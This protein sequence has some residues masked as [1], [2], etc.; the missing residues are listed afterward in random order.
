MRKSP[1]FVLFLFL[2]SAS[3]RAQ[4]DQPT[5]LLTSRD[6]ILLTVEDGKKYIHHPIKPKHTLFSISR[7]Y[8]IGLEELFEFNPGFRDDPTLR[9]ICAE[10][11]KARDAELQE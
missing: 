8:N 6:S 5:P 11:Y 4:D 9:E 10:A 1:L 3:L 7:Y 2:L